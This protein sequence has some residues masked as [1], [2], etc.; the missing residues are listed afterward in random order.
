[1]GFRL[2]CGVRRVDLE[3]RKTLVGVLMGH[4]QHW[5]ALPPLLHAVVI[6]CHHCGCHCVIIR[7]SV[8]MLLMAVM[9]HLV[10]GLANSK[11]EGTDLV[12]VHCLVATSQ[13]ATWQL[14]SLLL[15]PVM[16]VGDKCGG[17]WPLLVVV[18]MS[19]WW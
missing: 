16:V 18:S 8:A 19:Q 11:G 4:R 3:V 9:W 1:M 10:L 7:R 5:W 6:A 15:L 17:W 14:R 12:I 13:S 2:E